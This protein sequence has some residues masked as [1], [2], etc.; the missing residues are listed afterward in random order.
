MSH[1]LRFSIATGICLPLLVAAC[2]GDGAPAMG[3]SGAAGA[4]TGGRGGDGASAGAA[5]KG[6]S[7][8][9]AGKGGSTG[10]A[11]KGGSAGSS[12]GGAAGSSAHAGSAGADAATCKANADCGEAPK[13]VPAGCAEP[14]CDNGKCKLR[15]RDAD[16]DG[17]RA[18]R[19]KPANSSLPI[20]LGTDCNDADDTISPAGWDGP[21]ETGKANG[22]SDGVDQDCSGVADDGK[23]SKGV[24]CTCSPGDVSA[25]N[26]TSDGKP[27]PWPAF[28]P[29]GSPAGLCKRG[30][31]TCLANGSFGPCTGAVPPADEECNGQDDDCDGTA[32]EGPPSDAVDWFYDGDGDGY[33]SASVVSVKACGSAKPGTGAPWSSCAACV[34]TGW[35]KGATVD[36]LDCNDA[37]REVHP[38]ADD[39]CDD[40]VDTD[41][42]GSILDGCA[43][44]KASPC[45]TA[46]TLCPG[47]AACTNG[48]VGTCVPTSTCQC[49]SGV[50]TSCFD[51]AGCSG[52]QTCSNHVLG[53]CTKSGTCVPEETT[54]CTVAGE[55]AGERTCLKTSCL[56]S[57]CALQVD[58]SVALDAT[59]RS[60][61]TFTRPVHLLPG[62]YKLKLR[63]YWLGNGGVYSAGYGN[64]VVFAQ[65]ESKSDVYVSS[66]DTVYLDYPDYDYK[67]EVQFSVAGELKGVAGL[68][69][70]T[71]PDPNICKDEAVELEII[72][73]SGG[74]KKGTQY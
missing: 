64:A 12:S 28:D 40:Q 42:D 8:G 7:T 24:T 47:E 58:T 39:K 55:F 59:T 67:R 48:V 38:G 34:P 52:K 37:A 25:C 30:S 53:A 15:T 36:K 63:A 44:T 3:T 32:D 70:P 71:K 46:T 73:V 9:D 33:A 23:T 5:G 41:C 72:C 43:C 45:V 26:E 21:A 35:V 14:F 51:A 66:P 29:D 49:A 20:V 31:R 57:N 27:I 50:D 2:S 68:R 56:P 54:P 62:T 19:C 4:A 18:D 17:A 60:G 10:G 61:C 13:A 74:C 69:V 6:G 1:P 16:G 65:D 22:C 11:G